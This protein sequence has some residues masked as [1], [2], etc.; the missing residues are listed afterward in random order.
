MVI[1]EL[2][3]LA[4]VKRKLHSEED[5]NHSTRTTGSS[6]L[7][8]VFAQ[9]ALKQ[10]PTERVERGG[11]SRSREEATSSGK[12]QRLCMLC[13]LALTTVCLP[14]FRGYNI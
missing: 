14:D 10:T 6:S 11:E 13:A 9:S 5:T 4:Q 2:K 12:R 8:S 1:I 3:V 7:L